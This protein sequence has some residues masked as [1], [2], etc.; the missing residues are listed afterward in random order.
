M[1]SISAQQILKLSYAANCRRGKSLHA[2]YD[3]LSSVDIF[4][5]QLGPDHGQQNARLVQDLNCLTL[6]DSDH[7]RNF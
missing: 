7:Q 4:C 2:K 1:T 6:N 3:D 5:Q